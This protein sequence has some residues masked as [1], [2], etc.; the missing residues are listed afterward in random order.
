MNNVGISENTYV[1][2]T[3]ELYPNPATNQLNIV[4]KDLNIQSIAIK[5]IAG[6]TVLTTT[7]TL[8]IDVSTLPKG[9]YIVALTTENGIGYKRFVKQ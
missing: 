8:N 3:F 6:Q 5:N 2:S 9:T 4:A 1:L 7:N